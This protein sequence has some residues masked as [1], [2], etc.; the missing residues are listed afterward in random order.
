MLSGTHQ[1]FER[2]RCNIVP[3]KESKCYFQKIC[4]TVQVLKSRKLIQ[5]SGSRFLE[6][7]SLCEAVHIN[8][9]K[10][11]FWSLV[12]YQQDFHHGEERIRANQILDMYIRPATNCSRIES[13]MPLAVAVL[14]GYAAAALPKSFRQAWEVDPHSGT[15]LPAFLAVLWLGHLHQETILGGSSFPFNHNDCSFSLDR[16]LHSRRQTHGLVYVL[17]Q[18]IAA[19]LIIFLFF[20]TMPAF[21]NIS[22][23]CLLLSM[24]DLALDPLRYGK[25][26]LMWV[27]NTAFSIYFVTRV[28]DG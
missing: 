22:G 6:D 19:V 5:I 24:N 13:S 27:S 10:K 7:K 9:W 1:S 21:T 2:W 3:V 25:A 8:R 23:V 18:S 17:P 15:A 26:S 16:Y 12:P 14:G 4:M 28:H 11:A 20:Y